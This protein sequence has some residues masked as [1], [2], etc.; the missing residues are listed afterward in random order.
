MTDLDLDLLITAASQGGSTCLTSTTELAP[1][2]GPQAAVAPAKFAAEGRQQPMGTYA[3][4]DRYLD[5]AQAKAVLIDSKQSQLNRAEQGLRN[6]ILDDHPVL[7]RMPRVMVSYDRAGAVTEYSDLDLPHRIFDGH[8]RAGS[9]DGVPVTQLDQYRAIR[10]ADPANARALLDASPVSLV[11]GSWDSS[12]A[13]RQGRWRSTLVGEIIGF[14]ADG[15]PALKGGARTDPVGMQIQLTGPALKQLAESQRSELSAA[16]FDKIV[17]EAGQAKGDKRISASRVGL[18]GIPPTL[19]ALAGVACRRIIRSH[20]LSFAALRQ[21]RFGS[22]AEGDAACRALLAALAL[23]ALARSDSEL[24]LRA[25]CDLV[26]S[27]PTQ[28]QLDQRGGKAL[29]VTPLSI[30]AADQL[31]AAALSHAEHSAGVEWNGVV[32]RI[33]GDPAIVAGAADDAE[34]EVS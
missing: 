22:G 34:A 2:A 24:V 23:N 26:E 31:L 25:N 32:L 10:N 6:A 15:A 21:I 8:I 5:G 16:N 30:P 11:F 28:V 14:C 7:S 29:D 9:V 33:T 3:Y 17:K 13:T 19:A 4:E 1:A 12:R 27:A 18:G 20:V